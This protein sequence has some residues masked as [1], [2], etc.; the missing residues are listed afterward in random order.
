MI[1]VNANQ[2]S[3]ALL[4]ISWEA[5]F[6]GDWAVAN[7]HRDAYTYWQKPEA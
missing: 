3:L 5:T 6:T 1:H 2:A 7:P 4:N